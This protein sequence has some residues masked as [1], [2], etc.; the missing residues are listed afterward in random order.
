MSHHPNRNYHIISVMFWAFPYLLWQAF[1]HISGFFVGVLLAVILTTMFNGLFR[2]GN[3]NTASSAERQ[4]L[5]T[6]EPQPQQQE[7]HRREAEPYQ[8]GY[9]AKIEMLREKYQRGEHQPQYEE[10]LVLYP[11]EMPPMKQ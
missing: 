8:H 3:W 1:G 7:E 6:A 9:R 2:V 5:Q 4:S 11:Q 10:M